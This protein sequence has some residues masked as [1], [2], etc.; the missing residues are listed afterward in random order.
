ML[1]DAL[2]L[3][4]DGI[5]FY[6]ELGHAVYSL[7]H[8]DDDQYSNCKDSSNFMNSGTLRR[9]DPTSTNASKKAGIGPLKSNDVIIRQYQWEQI[10]K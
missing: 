1:R 5:T 4:A 2:G 9:G 6:H 3:V 8:P 7:R 10:H